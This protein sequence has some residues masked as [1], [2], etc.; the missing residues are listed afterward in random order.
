[1]VEAFKAVKDDGLSV[2]RAA[3][4]YGVPT[5]TLRDRIKGKIQQSAK[6][7]KESIFSHDEEEQ[8]VQYLEDLASIG[9]GL[10]RSQ[11]NILAGELALKLGRRDTDKRLSP[12]WYYGFLNRWDN[13]LKVTKPSS[14]TTQRAAAMTQ[15]AVDRYF[16]RLETVLDR[17]GFKDR[18]HHIFNMDETGLQPAH[19]P[20]RIITSTTSTKPQAITSPNST[21]VTMI[22]CISASGVALPPFY[23]F[24]GKR[25]NN[26]LLEGA[27][28]GSAMAMSDSGWSNGKVFID[29]MQRHFIK[30]AARQDPNEKLLLLFD[31]HASHC[32]LEAMDWAKQNNVILFVLPPHS[33]HALQPLDVGCFGPFK[34]AYYAACNHFM[35]QQR[36]RVVT[37]YDIAQISGIAYGKTMTP[38]NIIGGFRRAG[39]APFSSAKVNCLPD[40]YTCI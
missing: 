36:G 17:H 9:Y 35:A 5:Q 39:V 25:C 19:K 34:S 20:A 16:E 14:L 18:P 40:L 38:A 13:R 10:N 8:L 21:T 30:Y 15:E 3:K 29:Y 23:V 11:L 7:G 28:P 4:L 26:S 32:T 31:G 24:K 2:K 37:K 33:S 6:V 12:K 1:M 22:A 27:Q